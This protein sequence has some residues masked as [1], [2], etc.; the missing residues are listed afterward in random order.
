MTR[1]AH[2]FSLIVVL[3]LLLAL[4]A[5]ASTGV[6]PLLLEQQVLALERGGPRRIKPTVGP[7]VLISTT[8]CYIAINLGVTGPVDSRMSA[9]A[10]AGL[11]HRLGSSARAFS[12]ASRSMARS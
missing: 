8:P 10:S 5:L 7:S 3:G 11:F 12:S 1:P 2:G 9:C 6:A 4:S